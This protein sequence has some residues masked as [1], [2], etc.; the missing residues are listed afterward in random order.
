MMRD[1]EIKSLK[2]ATEVA[3]ETSNK[4]NKEL[5][6]T[7]LKFREE[8]A[9]ILKEHEAEVIYPGEGYDDL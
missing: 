9:T 3:Q 2:H 5:S 6:D 8:K 4:V 7:K 1:A